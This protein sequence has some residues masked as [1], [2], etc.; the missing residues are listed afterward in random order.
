VAFC[1]VSFAYEDRPPM[2]SDGGEAA[3]AARER[4]LRDLA[5]TLAPGRVLGLLGRTG[6]GK[7]T[8]ARLLLRLYDPTEGEV[9]LNGMPLTATTVD[10]VRRRVAL[11]TQEVQLFQASVR[12]NLTLFKP[13]I[14]DAAIYEVLDNLGLGPWLE[15]LPQGLDTE[16][17]SEGG[18][19]SAGQAQLLAFARVFLADPD[20]VILD[21]A[22]SRLDPATEQLIERAVDLLLADR[23]GIVIAHRLNTVRRADEVLI[24]EAGQ[25]REMGDRA[26]LADDPTSYFHHLLQTGMA[27]VL[28]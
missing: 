10:E 18:G 19:L 6:S 14:P 5:F 2:S 28:A 12:D 17:S 20:L 1:D 3:P 16:L 26:Q 22:S 24:L 21:E 23:T 11:V 7:T 13:H 25:I 4:V 15:S 9:C 27:E 8:L